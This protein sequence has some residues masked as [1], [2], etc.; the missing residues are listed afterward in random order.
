MTTEGL[1]SLLRK[2]ML[3]G[4]NAGFV[5]HRAGLWVLDID[6]IENLPLQVTDVLDELRPP[7]VRTPSGGRH[8]YFRLPD[9]L[10]EH[11]DLKAHMSLRKV[12]GVE[13]PIDLKLGGRQTMVV[14]PGSKKLEVRYQ[15]TQPWRLPPEL[16][17][18][19]LFPMVEI[20]HPSQDQSNARE[21]VRDG[22]PYR[23]RVVRAMN[24]LARSQAS[25]SGNGGHLVLAYVCAHLCGYLH[26]PKDRALELLTSPPG[27]SWND[28]CTDGTTGK[29]FPWTRS[30]LSLALDAGQKATPRFGVLMLERQRREL[31]RD[32]KVE[33]ACRTIRKL[34]PRGRA[35]VAV[36]EVYDLALK[37]MGLGAEDCNI[38]RF[39]RALRSAGVVRQQK[40]P[41]RVWSVRIQRGLSHLEARLVEA[42]QVEV[43]SPK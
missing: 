15:V 25:V 40:G 4:K 27:G 9:E 20:F 10:M 2:W 39:G 18:R 36:R 32:Q 16:D 19:E 14:A 26:I 41:Q 7:E 37:V 35:Y 24:F 42:F 30:E 23:D 28:R 31:E 8:C 17:P 1:V 34:M 21:F 33:L 6:T 43:K 12:P 22:R 29:S 11:P 13:L 5:I 3:T 38:V